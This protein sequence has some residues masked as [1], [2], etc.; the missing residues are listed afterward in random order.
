MNELRGDP[1]PSMKAV[2]LTCTG[3]SR[4]VTQLSFSAAKDGS[5]KYLISS[6]KGK[7]AGDRGNAI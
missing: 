2:P 1:E 5:S 4:P 7:K 3:H 6:C